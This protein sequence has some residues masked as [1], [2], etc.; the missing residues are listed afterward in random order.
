MSKLK[1]EI[2]D[3]GYESMSMFSESLPE[4]SIT[5]SFEDVHSIGHLQEVFRL[6]AIN[7]GFSYVVGV[8]C[9]CGRPQRR[10]VEQEESPEV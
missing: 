7:L 1:V 10:E 9:D 6:M 2:S 5:M 3:I 8:E 4:G